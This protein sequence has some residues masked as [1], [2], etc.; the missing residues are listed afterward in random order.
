MP[1]PAPESLD[2]RHESDV[3]KARRAGKIAAMGVGF[4]P[5]ESEEIVLVMIELATNLLKH[6][7][8]GRLLLQPIAAD[9]RV[10]LEVES[11]DGGPGIADVEQAMADRF[12]TAGS[13]GT[14][15]GAVNRLMDEMN[16][17]SRRGSGT[18]IVARKW[19]RAYRPSV[20][21]C[22]IEVGVATR[23]CRACTVNG[24][25]FVIKRW[26][27]SI[28]VGVVDGLGHGPF[29][30]QAAVTATSYVESHFDRPLDQIFIGVG[31]ACRST[32]GV[33]MALARFDWGRGQ[34]SFASIG[35]IGARVVPD[36]GSF[37]LRERRGIVGFNAP[38]PDVSEHVWP[39]DHWLIVHSDG[40]RARWTAT[41]FLELQKLAPA[42]AAERLLRD[43]A[44]ENDDATVLIARSDR[45]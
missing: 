1:A 17:A 28:L 14:G 31:R 19:V 21:P 26:S 4:G 20:R 18:R 15:L 7:Q 35:D 24:D 37:R 22:P 11:Q 39:P 27:E 29:A 38:N 10:G 30:H 13:R 34:M 9:G 6:A 43:H 42:A 12:S 3:G 16:I 8:G 36:A 25:S 45:A 33:V 5:D 41:D 32:R 23:P 40:I 2:I 44:E